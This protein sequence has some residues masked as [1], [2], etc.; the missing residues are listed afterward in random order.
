[1]LLRPPQFGKTAL[2]S[3]LAHYYDI[4]EAETFTKDF[5][6]LAVVAKNPVSVPQPNQ[7][8]CLLFNFS[9]VLTASAI[10]EFATNLTDEIFVVLEEF[11]WKYAG[12]LHISDPSDYLRNISEDDL[13]VKVIVSALLVFP[14]GAEPCDRIWPGPTITRFSLVST[15]MTPRFAKSYFPILTPLRLVAA[16]RAKRTL[17]LL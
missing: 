11:I 1:V 6:S 17:K 15:I 2:L 9:Q 14:S 13:L 16:L 5:G 10:D 3:T 4:H 7:H 8:L 12:E